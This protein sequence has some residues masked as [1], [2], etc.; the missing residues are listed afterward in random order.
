MGFFFLLLLLN[1][2]LAS[3]TSDSTSSGTVSSSNS[4]NM[5]RDEEEGLHVKSILQTKLSTLA[6]QII[7]CGRRFC[8]RRR[9]ELAKANLNELK[10]SFNIKKKILLYKDNF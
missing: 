9:K 10:S 6:L 4:S 2:I 8:Y 7:Y 5:S 1:I 3:L